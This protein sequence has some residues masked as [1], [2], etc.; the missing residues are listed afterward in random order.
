[1]ED[2]GGA[3]GRG[4]GKAGSMTK[5]LLVCCARHLADVA[6]ELF[7]ALQKMV[8]YTLQ[9]PTY[10][11]DVIDYMVLTEQPTIKDDEGKKIAGNQA[12]A[13][14]MNKIRMHA[15]EKYDYV[16]KMDADM[17]PPPH[18]L[19]TLIQT[20]VDHDALIVTSLTPERPSKCDTDRFSQLMSWNYNEGRDDEILVKIEGLEPF[21]CTGNAGEA[22]MLITRAALEMVEW[23]Y[24]S[25]GDFAFW[26]KVQELGIK[27]VCTPKVVCAH[28]DYE[29]DSLFI[30]GKEWVVNHWKDVIIKNLEKDTEW[31]HGLPYEW[32]YGLRTSKFLEILPYHLD[33]EKEP[34][35]FT[36]RGKPK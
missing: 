14:N 1:M 20:S 11:K 19:V 10:E 7:Q 31:Y 3:H 4:S 2:H 33:Q 17:I 18:A 15:I 29:A 23:P 6:P 16:V 25:N 5:V 24:R 22:F 8:T 27:V 12:R 32:W 13:W 36:Y 26:D 35:W 9:T 34:L 21:V 30:R 28:K